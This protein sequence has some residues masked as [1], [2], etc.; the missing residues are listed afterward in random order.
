MLCRD[1]RLLMTLWGD[2][3]DMVDYIIKKAGKDTVILILQMGRAKNFMGIG[4]FPNYTIKV[5]CSLIR[6][7]FAFNWIF[8]LFNDR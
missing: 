1:K 2:E 4:F 7:Y 3:A 8:F 6:I 5:F